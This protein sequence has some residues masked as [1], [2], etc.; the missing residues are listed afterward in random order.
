MQEFNLPRGLAECSR[1]VEPFTH[2]CDHRKRRADFERNAGEDQL[3]S[4]QRLPDIARAYT[5]PVRR[6]DDHLREALRCFGLAW[7]TSPGNRRPGTSAEKRI[8]GG[9]EP[10]LK[11]RPKSGAGC[12][13]VI[14][15]WRRRP[16]VRVLRVWATTRINYA[17]DRAITSVMSSCCSLPPLN[18]WTAPTTAWRMATAGR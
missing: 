13:G 7:P 14:A 18:C 5:I 6:I 3:P 15:L 12:S 10:H 16:P 1:G 2:G 9:R 17:R 8:S 4:V 11:L